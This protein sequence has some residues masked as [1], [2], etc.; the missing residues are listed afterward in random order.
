MVKGKLV[1]CIGLNQRAID[2][3][4]ILKQETYSHV[5]KHH[6]SRDISYTVSWFLY[7]MPQ[8][9]RRVGVGRQEGSSFSLSWLGGG[10]G[11]TFIFVGL[12]CW[13]SVIGFWCCLSAVV[14]QWM[15]VGC[16]VSVV[17]C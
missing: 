16:L 12:G 9:E 6:C 14:Y 17:E 5:H 11:E 2:G 13:V 10:G 3:Q 15:V 8:R 1:L 7:S 4:S